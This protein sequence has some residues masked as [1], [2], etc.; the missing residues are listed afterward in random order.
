M[1]VEN[2]E[3]ANI[4]A[5][6]AGI[7]AGTSY[8]HKPNEILAKCFADMDEESGKILAM[9]GLR[10][11]KK[12]SSHSTWYETNVFRHSGSGPKSFRFKS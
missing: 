11:H 6:Y 10:F 5:G 1:F 2:P 7:L 12:S 8:V 9:F 4:L 3:N